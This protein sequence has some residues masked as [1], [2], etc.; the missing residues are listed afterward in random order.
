MFAIS[1]CPAL[2][3]E[4]EFGVMG[5]RT[6]SNQ[7][8]ILDDLNRETGEP[9]MEL[10]L[11]EAFRPRGVIVAPNPGGHIAVAV[12]SKAYSV[13][14]V[15]QKK[16]GS[17]FVEIPLQDYLYG[18]QIPESFKGEE[19]EIPFGT[20]IGSCFVRTVWGVRVYK[21]PAKYNLRRISA[22]ARWSNEKA[23]ADDPL[24]AYK[25]RRNNCATITAK[26]LSAAGFGNY[27][28]GA[29]IFDFPRD[30]MTDFLQELMD[31]PEDQVSWEIVRY[32]QV[33]TGKYMKSQY[34]PNLEWQRII[35]SLPVLRHFGKDIPNLKKVTSRE[36]VVEVSSGRED[37]KIATA[38]IRPFTKKGFMSK[39]RKIF[40]KSE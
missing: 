38:V 16:C 1:L 3:S 27:A 9:I 10:M 17:I 32:E 34:V 29:H 23:N 13:S 5:G 4:S 6:I 7:T 36:V 24:I 11:S 15:Y 37:E 31:L 39:I 21:L 8:T 19:R 22:F 18:T 2:A 33:K 40:G 26:A 30:V 14:S 35:M 20:G 28:E 12:G 25:F